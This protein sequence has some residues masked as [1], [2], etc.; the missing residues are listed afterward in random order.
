MC[1]YILIRHNSYNTH[2]TVGCFRRLGL[3]KIHPDIEIAGRTP[4][5]H[6]ISKGTL[7]LY[8]H[9][10]SPEPPKNLPIPIPCKVPCH[11]TPSIFNATLAGPQFL[12][13]SNMKLPWFPSGNLCLPEHFRYSKIYWFT[14][15]FLKCPE[16]NWW[17]PLN[18]EKKFHRCWCFTSKNPMKHRL[19][20]A[21]YIPTIH[22]N[23]N[24]HA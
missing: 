8:V 7:S 2:L 14:I 21:S 18:P 19:F 10:P 15:A 13:K 23:V 4:K 3:P 12:N 6:Q 20:P 5:Y 17:I 11:L 1:I 9:L 16:T 24:S 22:G